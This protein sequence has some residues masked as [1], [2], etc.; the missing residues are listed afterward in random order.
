MADLTFDEAV[1]V[2]ETDRRG[3][4]APDPRHRG[5]D[6]RDDDGI[7]R[8][9][10]RDGSHSSGP[11]S[12]PSLRAPP[13]GNGQR[14]LGRHRQNRASASSFRLSHAARVGRMGRCPAR[15]E[16]TATLEARPEA[17]ARAGQGDRVDSSSVGRPRILSHRTPAT[18]D[19]IRADAGPRERRTRLRVR[20][21]RTCVRHELQGCREGLEQQHN[22]RS[23]CSFAQ[24]STNISR[25][26]KR[27]EISRTPFQE[28]LWH[29]VVHE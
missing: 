8:R 24:R 12:P 27:R 16:T 20:C 19:D 21:G 25:P 5:Q 6:P 7:H 13:C 18:A 2:V 17:E 22:I 23:G 26:A 11:Q 9:G 14:S 15:R 29:A 3:S 4:Q 10:L 28:P 1:K